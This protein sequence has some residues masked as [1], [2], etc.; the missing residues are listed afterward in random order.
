MICCL[1]FREESHLFL[2]SISSGQ[3]K[4][5][6]VAG[7]REVFV[8]NPSDGS[9]KRYESGQRTALYAVEMISERNELVFGGVE[10]NVYVL[11]LSS[12]RPEMLGSHAGRVSSLVALE[13]DKLLVSTGW[14]GRAAVWDIERTTPCA[15]SPHGRRHATRIGRIPG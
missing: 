13:K 5:I 1:V 15:R 10:G 12:G 4:E 9:V 3:T 11:D 2:F 8:V 14:D 6:A 7:A